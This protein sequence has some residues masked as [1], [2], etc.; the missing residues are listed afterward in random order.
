MEIGR[1]HAETLQLVAWCGV[2]RRKSWHCVEWPSLCCASCGHPVL[3]FEAPLLRS[4]GALGSSGPVGWIE[5]GQREDV[6]L[7]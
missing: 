4:A 3:S 1:K 2:C 7:Q 6:T 5:A